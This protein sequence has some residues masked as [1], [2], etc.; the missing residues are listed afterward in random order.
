MVSALLIL[1][2]C[3]GKEG[4]KDAPV[5]ESSPFPYKPSRELVKSFLETNAF[6]EFDA[7]AVAYASINPSS[8]AENGVTEEDEAMMTAAIYRFYKH[9]SVVDSQYV[10]DVECGAD[11]NMSDKVF[12]SFVNNL[13]DINRHIKEVNTRGGKIC[14]SEPNDEYFEKLLENTCK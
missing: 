6:L 9:V 7:D 14:I 10:W 12:E 1:M 11:I 13:E 2:G 5:V 4:V 3:V 8:R